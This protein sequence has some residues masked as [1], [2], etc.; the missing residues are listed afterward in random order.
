M[1]VDEIARIGLH[2]RMEGQLKPQKSYGMKRVCMKTST[3][4]RGLTV[5]PQEKLAEIL[6]SD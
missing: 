4:V 2:C 1:L 5:S 3:K 6:P